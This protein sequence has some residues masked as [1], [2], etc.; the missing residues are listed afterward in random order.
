VEIGDLHYF[1]APARAFRAASPQRRRAIALLVGLGAALLWLA[2]LVASDGD[3]LVRPAQA[4]ALVAA[5]C[6][7]VY[8]PEACRCLASRADTVFGTAELMRMVERTGGNVF[9]DAAPGRDAVHLVQDCMARGRA[10]VAD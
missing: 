1:A 4:R 9:I 6:D 5:A 7:D 10:A 3:P 8:A 2:L